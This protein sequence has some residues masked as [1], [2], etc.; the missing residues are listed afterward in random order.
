[1]V[2]P[3]ETALSVMGF[4]VKVGNMIVRKSCYGKICNVSG[5]A[6]TFAPILKEDGKI[7]RIVAGMDSKKEGFIPMIAI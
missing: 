3:V 2:F 6:D 5:N 1:M 7:V 4:I